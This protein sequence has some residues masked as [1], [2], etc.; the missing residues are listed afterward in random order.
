MVPEADCEYPSM[1]TPNFPERLL[2]QDTLLGIT[3]EYE[4]GSITLGCLTDCCLAS[5][6]YRHVQSLYDENP[7]FTRKVHESVILLMYDLAKYIGIL[8]AQSARA[9]VRAAL[10]LLTQWEIHLSNNSLSELLALDR[11]TV[12]REL[13]SLK[14]YDAELWSAY[15]RTKSHRVSMLNP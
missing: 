11:T 6:K 7:S 5:F 4:V 9:K 10:E 1:Y 3:H 2:Y 8:R 13:S 14:R 15:M 12:S